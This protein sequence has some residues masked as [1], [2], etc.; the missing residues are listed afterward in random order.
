MVIHIRNGSIYWLPFTCILSVLD[1]V[2]ERAIKL[3]QNVKEFLELLKIRN[4]IYAVC[5]IL[6][7]SDISSITHVEDRAINVLLK[8]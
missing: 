3:Q 1:Y 4:L 8:V 7:N 2:S 5:L 6:F